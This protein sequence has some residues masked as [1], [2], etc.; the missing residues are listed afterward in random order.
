M[1]DERPPKLD[2]STAGPQ[3]LAR[4]ARFGTELE[5]NLVRMRLE[6]AGI[7]VTILGGNYNSIGV[8]LPGHADVELMVPEHLLE[9]AQT[10]LESDPV[11]VDESQLYGDV[12]FDEEDEEEDVEDEEEAEE[13]EQEESE[14]AIEE[15]W[16]V[17]DGERERPLRVALLGYV[18]L[19]F[20]VLSPVA[21]V[22]FGMGLRQSMTARQSPVR[23]TI[24]GLLNLLG[25]AGSLYL[26]ILLVRFIVDRLV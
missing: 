23:R 26:S 12:V 20:V 18:L 3:R 25:L 13:D 16:R 4:L 6:S 1:N 5:A 22:V 2:Y 24:A 9:Q 14:E 15:R 7:A 21:V 11:V 19:A 10:I 8:A 17:E